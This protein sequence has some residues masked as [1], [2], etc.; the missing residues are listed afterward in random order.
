[1]SSEIKTRLLQ[2]MKPGESY[3]D[4]IAKLIEE[5]REETESDICDGWA[6]RAKE[7]IGEYQR[8]ET[9]PETDMMKIYGI[10]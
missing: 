6:I 9:V 10:E 2:M 3:E 5:H 4:V 1:V 7:A 8:G